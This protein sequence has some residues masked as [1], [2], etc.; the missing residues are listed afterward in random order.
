MEQNNKQTKHCPYCGEEILASAKKCRYCGEWLDKDAQPVAK[1]ESTEEN[2]EDDKREPSKVPA[3]VIMGVAMFIALFLIV[4]Y[5]T[6]GLNLSGHGNADNEPAVDTTMV[7]T[8]DYDEGDAYDNSDYGESDDNSDADYSESDYG[9]SDDYYET[10]MRCKGKFTSGGTPVELVFSIDQ[11][12]NISDGTVRAR[13]TNQEF[14]DLTG[15][16]SGKHLEMTFANGSSQV[17][18][19]IIDGNRMTGTIE[20][21]EVEFTF[22]AI[23]S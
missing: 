10:G 16:L 9:Q 15:R 7:D 11:D 20:G 1:H 13:L 19:D 22:R 8:M 21:D 2:K 23:H 12:G 17:S 4:F 3:M 14:N 6:N 18:L 5:R